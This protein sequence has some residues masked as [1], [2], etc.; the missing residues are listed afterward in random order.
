MIRKELSSHRNYEEASRAKRKNSEI[1]ITE[2][3]IRRVSTGFK[4]VHRYDESKASREP[5]K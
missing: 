4:L 2:L 1:P 5:K 3:Q